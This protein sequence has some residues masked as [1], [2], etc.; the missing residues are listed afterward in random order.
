[1]VAIKMNTLFKSPLAQDQTSD[2]TFPSYDGSGHSLII[3][4]ISET[5][6]VGKRLVDQG[7]YR[8]T[9]TVTERDE[10]VDEKL[11]KNSVSV[12]LRAIGTLLP[13]ME[14]PAPRHEG[15]TL[16]ISVVEEV[17]VTEKRLMLKE[18]L[19]IT[20]SEETVRNP[21]HVS[22]RSES[23]HIEPLLPTTSPS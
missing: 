14:T 17:L 8:I 18:E 13:T 1:M 5:L 6:I 7:G 3:P 20:R 21:V 15:N 11:K 19:R 2:S 10:R 23:V 4:V 22:V 16:I 9:K 12:E